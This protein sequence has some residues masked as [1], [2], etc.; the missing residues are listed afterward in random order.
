MATRDERRLTKT[1][2][3]RKA[4]ELVERAYRPVRIRTFEHC[5]SGYWELSRR[6]EDVLAG[7]RKGIVLTDDYCPVD[8]M[9]HDH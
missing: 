8:T 3:V 7:M 1:D 4:R 2:I 9:F 5:A 6:R